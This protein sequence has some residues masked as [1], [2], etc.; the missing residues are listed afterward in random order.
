MMGWLKARRDEGGKG[1]W[2][3]DEWVGEW[4]GWIGERGR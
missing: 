4:M 2:M 1:G 3:I